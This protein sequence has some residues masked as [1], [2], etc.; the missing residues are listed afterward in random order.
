MYAFRTA[1]LFTAIS[2]PSVLCAQDTNQMVQRCH[3]GTLL[4]VD[5]RTEIVPTTSTQHMEEKDKHGKKVYDGYSTP[6]EAKRTTYVLQVGVDGMVYTVESTPLFGVFSYKPTD[7][8][9][10]DSIEVCVN[11]K[12]LVL[13]RP[14]GKQFKTKIVRTA[15]DMQ[16]AGSGTATSQKFDEDVPTEPKKSKIDEAITH[17]HISSTPAGAEIHVDGAYVGV[18]PSDI[19]LACCSHDLTITKTG[20]KSWTRAVRTTGGQVNISAELQQ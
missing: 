13:T 4:D 9:V 1:I 3:T 14:N 8:V 20:L 15:R 5:S 2:L 11:G 10:G 16:S 18:T 6:N 19:D 17:A 7:L 12:S